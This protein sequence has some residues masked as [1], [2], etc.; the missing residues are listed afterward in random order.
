MKKITM[1]R[2]I[3]AVF[4]LAAFMIV[5]CAPSNV[6][7]R[8]ETVDF[9]QERAMLMRSLERFDEA[10]IYIKRAI[11]QGETSA[12]VLEHLGDVYAKLQR[13]EDAQ[14]Y[15]KKA[16]EMDAKNTALKEK[17]SRGTL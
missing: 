16:F 1:I 3:V 11:E 13:M 15:W 4:V 6:K 17:I 7:M 5:G 8:R 9:Q 2:I 12:V 10:L 14:K